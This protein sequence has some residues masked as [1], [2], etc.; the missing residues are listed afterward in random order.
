MNT[1]RAAFAAVAVS[2][3]RV[4]QG[5]TGLAGELGHVVVRPGGEQ[6]P[7]GRSGCLERYASAAAIARH[8][9]SP[10]AADVVAALDTDPTAAMYGPFTYY[11]DQSRG[12]IPQYRNRFALMAWAEWLTFEP[13][14]SADRITVPTLSVHSETAAIP[15]GIRRFAARLHAPL[16]TVWLDDRTQFDFYDDD[17][18]VTESVEHV[19]RHLNA[20]L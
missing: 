15:D 20:T 16:R 3:G 19:A 6:C 8:H 17:R 18:T 2:G 11:L 13:A 12:A 1:P 9:G 4:V 14:E 7:C 10:S 5:A